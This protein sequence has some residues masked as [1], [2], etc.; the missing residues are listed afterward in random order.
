MCFIAMKRL[1]GGRQHR[2]PLRHRHRHRHH[3]GHGDRDL[4]EHPAAPATRPDRTRAG[5]EVIFRASREVGGAVLTAVATTVVSFLPVFTMEAAEGKLFKPLAF[6][7]TF[8]LIASVIVA[9]TVIPAVRARCLHPAGRTAQAA[10][11]RRSPWPA[12]AIVRAWVGHEPI[13]V[14]V[15]VGVACVL[16]R[17]WLPLGPEKG[18]AA[19]LHLRRPAHR[20]PAAALSSCSSAAYPAHAPLVPRPQGPG[21]AGPA[22]RGPLRRDD[23]AR[24]RRFLR[25]APRAAAARGA[26]GPAWP[27]PS[28]AWARS[29]CRRW[30]RARISDAHHHAPRLH[31]RGAWTCCSKQDMAISAIP[32]V[33]A[34]VGK[35]GRVESPL[36][37]APISMIETV[38]NYHPSICPG[39]GRQAAALPLRRRRERLFRDQAGDPVPAPDGQP[40]VVQWHVPPRRAGQPDPRRRRP[41]LPALAARRSTRISTTAARPGPA[42]RSRTTSGTRSSRRPGCPGPPR[43][44]GSSRSPPASSCCRAACARPWGSR[45][46]GRTWR[47]SSGSAWRSRGCSRR[48]RRSSRRRCSPTGSWASRTSRSTS[49]ARPSPATGSC[50]RTCRT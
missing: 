45:S 4:R 25:L 10:A 34:A 19:Q 2:R 38:I 22:L 14:A 40:Y 30:T 3:G 5:C 47:P 33:E 17:H 6:T 28:P 32:E 41:A 13:A 27:T 50:S 42:S 15:I 7:K 8:A 11:G 18:F 29:S 43:P 21:P 9:L 48:C 1:R 23:L 26:A 36:D 46:R 20:R 24:L 35:L 37:P 12:A 31:R 49:T 44:R 16:R 39:R